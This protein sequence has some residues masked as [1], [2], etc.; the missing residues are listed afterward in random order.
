MKYF[1]EFLVNEKLPL[2]SIMDMKSKKNNVSF[3]PK[4]KNCMTQHGMENFFI[5]IPL[6]VQ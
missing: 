2:K 5:N 3:C 1:E 6:F 4:F